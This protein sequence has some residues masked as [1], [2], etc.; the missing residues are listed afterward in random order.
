MQFIEVTDLA[1]VRSAVLTFRCRASTVSFVLFPMVHLGE[2][3]FY[4]QV[5]ARLRRCDLVLAEGVSGESAGV[6]A[7]VGAYRRL[8]GV[9]RLGLVVQDIDYVS[10]GVPVVNPDMSGQDFERG[11]RRLPLKERIAVT[12][13]VP[14]FAAGMRLLGTRRF[15]ARHLQTEDLRSDA[16]EMAA[17][18]WKGLDELV[19][20][21]RDRL[22]LDAL[23]GIHERRS[24]SAEPLVVGVVYGAGHMGAAA[25]RLW[26]LGYRP[27]DSE[28]LTV[29]R[30]DPPSRPGP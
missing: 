13:L 23:A 18:W 6:D 17:E 15:L 27:L 9:E 1:G 29:F 14:A 25:K 11:F 2:A 12:T 10:L 28:W 26:A 30:L 19:L 5:T 20:D 21:D 4:A 7:L 3:D 24:A 8:E 16:E 22:L